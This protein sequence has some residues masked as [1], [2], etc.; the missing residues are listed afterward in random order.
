MRPKA[1][2]LVLEYHEKFLVLVNAKAYFGGRLFPLWGRSDRSSARRTKAS[3]SRLG[4]ASSPSISG[5]A[6]LP[7]LMG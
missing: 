3:P 4:P 6:G 7:E 5:P 1:F 2:A